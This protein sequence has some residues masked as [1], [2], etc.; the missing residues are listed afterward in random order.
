MY[1]LVLNNLSPIQQGIQFGHALQEYNNEMMLDIADDKTKHDF[2]QWRLNDKTFI[3]LNGGTSNSINKK[4]TLNQH[5][6][7]LLSGNISCATFHEPDLN[8]ALTAIVFPVRENVYNE[9]DYPNFYKW[10]SNRY[11]SSEIYN[12]QFGIKTDI[13][14]LFPDEYI[15]WNSIVGEDTITFR[16]WLKQFKLA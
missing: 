13:K 2:N 8:D 7:Y 14:E 1:G 6:A 3:I 5:L 9:I 16:T 11:G 4:G 10:L 15:E 12:K